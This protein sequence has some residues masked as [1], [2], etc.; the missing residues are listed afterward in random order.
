ML[1]EVCVETGVDSIKARIHGVES[2]IHAVKS[3][4]HAVESCFDPASLHGKACV[5]RVEARID[6]ASHPVD[7]GAEVEQ[8]AQQPSC[9]D[10]ERRPHLRHRLAV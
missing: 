3:S 6:P 8:G 1:S 9:Q 5:H 7:P 2:R 4:I 10:P